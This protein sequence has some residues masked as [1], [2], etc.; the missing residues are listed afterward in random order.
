MN[1]RLVFAVLAFLLIAAAGIVC[2]AA[3]IEAADVTS[4]VSLA[5]PD[6]GSVGEAI[7]GSEYTYITVPAG[8]SITL[9]GVPVGGIYV[10]FHL[11]SNEWKL[12]D[13]ATEYSC[14][15]NGFLHEWVPLKT[16]SNHLV[17][18]FPEE[19]QICELRVFDGAD[20]PSDV[21]VWQT[22]HEKA[23]AVLLSSH[24]DDEQL[25]FAGLIPYCAANDIDL[26]VVYF[27]YHD[28]TPIRL[29]EQLNGLWAAG[30][31][32]YPEIGR[33]PDLYSESLDG[34]ENAFAAYGYTEDDFIKYQCEIIRRYKPEVVIGHDINGEYGHGTHRLNTATLMKALE[35]SGDASFYPDS[36]EKYGVWDV[37]KTY[38]HLFGERQ[39]V[40][41]Y[42]E[43]LDYFGGR[44][45]YQMSVEG[46][47]CHN[48]QHW[49]WFTDW[50]LGT[51][52]TPITRASD[53][54]TYSPCLF[55]LYRTTVGDDERGD[56]FEHIT[57]RRDIPPETNPP[58]TETPRVTEE[59]VEETMSVTAD[60][61]ANSTG[62]D[63]TSLYVIFSAVVLSLLAVI[64]VLGVNSMGGSHKRRR[65][66][67]RG[68]R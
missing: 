3:P 46:Y 60:A 20:A 49:T 40:M 51:D 29:H 9:D 22:P 23:D 5:M 6:G 53:I 56:M 43:P 39:I 11:H 32:H 16:S 35:C 24:S 13:G 19:T 62:A 18:T 14:G 28:D 64:A 31:T 26:Q 36:S 52:A 1:K 34:A 45:A 42:D 15:E 4:S 33:F 61:P 57:L 38:L 59:S 30:A 17:M 37:P 44:T 47:G 48:S 65:N 58:E 41:N 2:E 25:F 68:R 27:C 67:R 63:K 55:G 21:Q 8:G 66:R 54:G 7:D 12:S 10:K 50:L